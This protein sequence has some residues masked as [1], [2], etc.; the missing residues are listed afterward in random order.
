M[1]NLKTQINPFYKAGD[2]ITFVD[3]CE[4][5]NGDYEVLAHIP[6][7]ANGDEI[8]S[9][10]EISTGALMTVMRW[11]VDAYAVQF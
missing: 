10:K 6:Q 5:D 3:D 8:Y 4:M 9:L 1:K 7:D 11:Y 2:I